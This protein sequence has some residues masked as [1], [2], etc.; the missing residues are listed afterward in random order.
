MNKTLTAAL[1]ASAPVFLL[2]TAAH[3]EFAW[4]GEIEIGNE[5][6]VSSDDPANEIRDTYAIFTAYGRYSFGNGISVFSVLTGESMTDAT[7]DRTF[8]DMGL[9]VEELGLSF[10]LGE[11][12][13]V[14]AGKLHPVF[15][16]A[17]DDTAGFFGGTLAEDYELKEQIG[18]LADV[19]LEGAG[20]LSFGT[21]FADDTLLSRSAGFDRGRNTTAAG[22][23]GNTGKLNN[24]AIQWSQEAGD[25]SFHLGAR[26]LSAGTGDADDEQGVV[27]GI[28]HSFAGGFDAFAEVAAFS[29]F[30]GSAD[31]ATYAT[32]NGAYAIGSLT[33]SGTL[34]R[35]DLDSQGD[36]DLASLAAEYEFRN[37]LTLGGAVARIDD[38]GT[39]D[40]VIGV[41]LLVPLGG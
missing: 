6:V 33:L 31:D 23:A 27:A 25:T 29:H 41:N 12:A 4:E 21:F 11:A 19:E 24:F 14:S 3:A 2:A 18:I 40:T 26:H 13:T 34:A 37:G 39:R 28:G 9:F 16:S 35:R 8:D 15:G 32:L 1:A 5:Q 30:G 22:G 20:T 7:A 17:W 36:T 38:S 10:A